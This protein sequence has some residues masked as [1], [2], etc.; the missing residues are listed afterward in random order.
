LIDSSRFRTQHKATRISRLRRFNH[1]TDALVSLHWL[2]VPKRIVF[3]VAVQL[4]TFFYRALHGDAHCSAL[5]PAVHVHRRHPVATKTPVQS[6][7]SNH[8]LVP[9][10]RISLLSYMERLLAVV[11]SSPSLLT[12]NQR[13]KCTYFTSHFLSRSNLLIVL[14][15]SYSHLVVFVAAVYCLGASDSLATWRYITLD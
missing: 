6:S 11:T 1:I 8:L 12:L 9:A 14:T 2:R 10:V 5:P 3:K 13:L 4:Q 7:G 15:V